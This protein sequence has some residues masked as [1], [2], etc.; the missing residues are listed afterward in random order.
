MEDIQSIFGFNKAGEPVPEVDPEDVKTVWNLYRDVATRHPGQAVGIGSSVVEQA[1]KPGANAFAVS[2]RR[3]MLHALTAWGELS[4]WVRD[5]ELDD[6]LF[7]VAAT[8][9]MK[10]MGVGVEHQGLPLDEEDFLRRVR[11]ATGKG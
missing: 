11:E 7:Q 1:C 5:G 9:P 10:W 4:P 6:A 2:Y 3:A 8:V